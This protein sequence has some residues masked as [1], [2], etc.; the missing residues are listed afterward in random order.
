MFL[1]SINIELIGQ[2]NKWAGQQWTGNMKLYIASDG[3][4]LTQIK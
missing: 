1:F 2:E 4:I 3:I